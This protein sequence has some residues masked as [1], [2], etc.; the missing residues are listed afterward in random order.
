MD[1]FELMHNK[2]EDQQVFKEEPQLT[3]TKSVFDMEP[4]YANETLSKE[5]I[6]N[7]IMLKQNDYIDRTEE[8]RQEDLKEKKTTSLLDRTVAT[9][10]KVFN[11]DFS[12]KVLKQNLLLFKLRSAD[13]DANYSNHELYL[14]MLDLYVINNKFGKDESIDGGRAIDAILRLYTASD[15]FVK[16]HGFSI[17]PEAKARNKAAKDSLDMSKE[18]FNKLLTADDEAKIQSL[19]NFS[20]D[21]TKSNYK[22]LVADMNSAAKSLKSF[23]TYRS[24]TGAFKTPEQIIEAKLRS[25]KKFDQVIRLY[26]H[27]IKRENWSGRAKECIEEYENLLRMEMAMKYS[28]DLKAQKAKEAV[29]KSGKKEETKQKTFEQ[30]MEEHLEIEDKKNGRKKLDPAKVDKGLTEAQLKGIDQIDKWLIANAE[31]GGLAGL[32]P[33]INLKNDNA[34]FV[35]TLLGKSKR[36]RLYIYYMVESNHRKTPTFADVA[37]SQNSYIPTL[38][39]FTDRML[40]TKLKAY[41]Y[42]TGDYTYMHKLS[43]ANQLGEKNQDLIER[44]ANLQNNIITKEP[45]NENPTPLEELRQD[46]LKAY[47]AVYVKLNNFRNQLLKDQ[48]AKGADKKSAEAAAK[49]NAAR[50]E[51]ELKKLIDTDVDLRI[52]AQAYLTSQDKEQKKDTVN[53]EFSKKSDLKEQADYGN[54]FLGTV[55]SKL[56]V[57]VHATNTMEYT[58]WTFGLDEKAWK[59]INMWAGSIANSLFSVCSIMSVINSVI[60]MVSNHSDMTMMEMMQNTVNI[61]KGG[62]DIAKAGSTM[63]DIISK[64]GDF[65]GEVL[66]KT[67]RALG[68][69][70]AG[71]DVYMAG[72]NIYSASKSEKAYGTVKKLFDDKHAGMNEADQQTKYEKGMLKL[73]QD[74]VNKKYTAGSYHVKTGT[75]TILSLV[76]PG[77][78]AILAGVAGVGALVGT[79]RDIY[80]TGKIRDAMFDTYYNVDALTK[81]GLELKKQKCL[82][83]GHYVEP[84]I[85]MFRESVRKSICDAAGYSGVDTA[86][87][88]I[89][90][91]YADLVRDKLF[92]ENPALGDERKAYM[93]ILKLFNLPYD[94]KK[95]IPSREALCRKMK[96]K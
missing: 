29:E 85:E 35:N 58:H 15:A 16:S 69:I 66:S 11:K 57:G 60:D 94:E 56:V 53:R 10:V 79:I 21:I 61:V 64:G 20:L 8:K 68:V 83:P 77:A 9:K 73:S 82:D 54:I 47:E 52:R 80:K 17:F 22:K 43:Q 41:K 76:I 87:E 78:G 36:E 34:N 74:L 28:R 70:S 63:V 72:T 84:N 48:A 93:G 67:T 13:K 89:A 71:A 96:G 46:R 50:I 1:S 81:K 88:H 51:A 55:P 92:G 42:F 30:L 49:E 19:G 25:Y 6:D 18:F 5:Q 33:F 12:D 3:R 65:G 39:G 31:N 26:R 38:K 27:Y 14:S 95:K 2:P 24:E 4:V 7:N 75:C 32:L 59:S 91:E 23:E 90:A 62:V 44:T 45:V 86:T 40:A 37:I